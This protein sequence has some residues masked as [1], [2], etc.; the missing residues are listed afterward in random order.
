MAIYTSAGCSTF[1]RPAS[2]NY[3]NFK[4]K[5]FL[6]LQPLFCCL[7]A[8]VIILA[9]GTTEVGGDKSVKKHHFGFCQYD[10]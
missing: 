1:L 5:S 8:M 4:V 6:T 7:T 3:C 9:P 2:I 10:L